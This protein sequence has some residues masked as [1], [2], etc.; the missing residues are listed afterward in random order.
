[1]TSAGSTDRLHRVAQESC[2]KTTVGL[3]VP[4]SQAGDEHIDELTLF[5]LQPITTVV[6]CKGM[7]FLCIAKVNGLF[8]NHLPVNN[9]PISLLSEKVAQVLYQGLRLVPASYS[10]DHDRK[11]D[12]RSKDLFQLSEKVPGS[13]ILPINPD[14]AS[15]S[16]C[17]AFLLFQSSELMAVATS[18][19]DDL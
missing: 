14:V 19:R 3:G 16:I 12:W 8:L 6:V 4:H 2:F 5:I 9:I 7:L 18:L 15:H 13:L 17:D 10:D 11:H 1:V